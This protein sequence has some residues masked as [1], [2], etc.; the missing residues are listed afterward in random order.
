MGD[1]IKSLNCFVSK[2]LNA[3][4]IVPTIPKSRNFGIFQSKR[5]HRTVAMVEWLSLSVFLGG[6]GFEPAEVLWLVTI[7][8][9][10]YRISPGGMSGWLQRMYLALQHT[11]E[12]IGRS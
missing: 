5:F 10:I 2:F 8:T 6:L 11:I 1:A 3:L 9:I 12:S 7:G 4:V